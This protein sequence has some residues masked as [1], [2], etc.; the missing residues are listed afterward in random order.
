MLM[1]RRAEG[2]LTLIEI[3]VATTIG[4]VVMA[5]IVMVDAGRSRMQVQ[6]LDAS[7]QTSEEQQV[8]VAMILLGKDLERADRVNILNTGVPGNAPYVSPPGFGNVLIRIPLGCMGA[9]PPPSCFNTAANYQ[10]V[11]YRRVGNELRLYTCGGPMRVIARELGDTPTNKGFEIR[12]KNTEADPPPWG[13]PVVDTNVFE[14]T[15]TWDNGLSGSLAR[16][17]TFTGTSTMRNFGYMNINAGIAGPGDSGT[18]LPDSMPGV[19]PMPP[20][21]GC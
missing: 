4:M 8:G 21:G 20:P 16:E 2:G 6:L 18:G 17:H 5:G 3:I 10:W 11:Q 13:G 19:D 9:A 12:Y 7:K 14:Y 15:I 1:V